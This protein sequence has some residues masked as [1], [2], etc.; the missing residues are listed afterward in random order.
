MG[1]KRTENGYVLADIPKRKTKASYYVSGL[2]FNGGDMVK[3]DAWWR[4]RLQ[5]LE[6]RDFCWMKLFHVLPEAKD[7]VEL[8]NMFQAKTYGVVIHQTCTRLIIEEFS[9]FPYRK[10]T[11]GLNQTQKPAHEIRIAKYHIWRQQLISPTNVRHLTFN[12]LSENCVALLWLLFLVSLLYIRVLFVTIT[13]FSSCSFYVSFSHL[14]CF[15]WKLI[16]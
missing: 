7:F 16:W 13:I 9:P 12:F 2:T 14:F 8:H 10:W 4:P 5:A 11:S 3:S 6:L 15:L 1:Q